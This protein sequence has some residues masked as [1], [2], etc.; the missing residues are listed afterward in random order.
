MKNSNITKLLR[1]NIQ[2]LTPY[3][4]ARDEYT[5]EANI[6]LDANEN[7]IGSAI[8]GDYNRYPD[9]AQLQLK[10]K[11]AEL[12]GVKDNQ[13][14]L[15]NGSDEAIDLLFRAFC[16]PRKDRALI[17]PPTYGMYQVQANINNTPIEEILLNDDFSLPV[18]KV[19]QVVNPSIKMMFIC[20]PNNP[21]GNLIKKE[22]II[23]ILKS[24]KGIVVVDEAYIDFAE[25]GSVLSEIN[26]YPNLVVL[27]TFSK[28]WGLAGIRLGMAFANL[29]IIEVLNKIKYPYNINQ[30]T[31]EFAFK[32]IERVEQ[33]N[34]MIEVIL[35]ERTNLIKRLESL[36]MVEKVYPTDANFILVKVQDANEIYGHLVK[37][38]IIVRNRNNVALCEN[39]LRITVGNPQEN[40][41]LIKQ[42]EHAKIY[43][44]V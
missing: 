26:N 33:K 29:E 28:A 31:S 42:L 40:N 23:R 34:Q 24:F 25:K 32:A 1:T 9:P 7:S 17:F 36:E 19:E 8:L 38:G 18:E 6:F 35:A 44:P 21:T 30:L 3:S 12:K 43:Q 22:S 11:I 37:K 27:Q 15:G 39:C 2:E 16:A 14:F 4:S 10:E 5:G 41:E 13:I 20:S